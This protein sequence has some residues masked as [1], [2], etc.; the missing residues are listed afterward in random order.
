MK[1][2]PMIILPLS[3]VLLVG[4]AW[5]LWT[6]DRSRTEL[7][8]KYLQ[9]GCGYREVLD[10]RL[11][12]CDT[13]PRDAPAV[14]LL[15]GFGASLQT[16]DA[17]AKDLAVDHRVI[18][19]DLPGAGLTGPDPTGDYRD[20]RSIAVLDALMQQLGV[21]RA[22]V[23]GNSIGGRIAWTFAAEKP[24]RVDK[25]IL[26]SPDGFSSPGFA[27]GKAPETPALL[28]LMRYVLPKALVRLNLAPA[29]G[30]PKALSDA[31]VT[32]Y[33]DLMLVPGLRGAMLERMRQTVLQN[34]APLLR[35]IQA[36]TLLLWGEK[37]AMIPVTNAADY[38]RDLP[39][40]QLVRL[41]G[42]G[43]VPQE[44]APEVSLVPVRAFL[45]R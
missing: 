27:Y 21:A 26:I 15:H 33:Y 20:S 8:R 44:E 31:V 14:I 30:D 38:V 18:R 17:W 37:D 34:P 43:H 42:L 9:A 10:V 29:Y 22:S 25:L 6:P 36:P 45:A 23:V 3:L 39:K 35:R 32:R 7:E 24:M 5:W 12:L 1:S 4:A 41:P 13:G 28:S 16:W 40:S 2:V 11:H 19:F